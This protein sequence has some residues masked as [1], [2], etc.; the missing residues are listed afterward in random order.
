MCSLPCSPIR[1][2]FSRQGL[3]ARLTLAPAQMFRAR[4]EQARRLSLQRPVLSG[5]CTLPCPARRQGQTWSQRQQVIGLHWVGQN[6]PAPRLHEKIF[7]MM[8][9]PDVLL[10]TGL[11]ELRR[12]ALSRYLA[13]RAG[14]QEITASKARTRTPAI[15]FAMKLVF[16]SWWY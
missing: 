6:Q 1:R 8:R 3:L 12:D 11:S 16:R 10:C 13:K 7:W 9:E 14:N 15:L 5:G 4:R 2:N